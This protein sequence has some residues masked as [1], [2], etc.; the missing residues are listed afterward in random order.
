L[1]ERNLLLRLLSALV[2]IPVVFTAVFWR[3][4]WP[5]ALLAIAIGAVGLAELGHLVLAVQPPRARVLLIVV[6]TAFSTA[7]YLWP[8]KA[9]LFVIAAIVL[10]GLD[11]LIAAQDMETA[12]RRLGMSAFGI[13]YVG[14]LMATLP[15]LRRDAGPWWVIT[16]FVVTFAND[17]GA[18]FAGRAL[19][20][21]KLA[22]RI[23]PGK[24]VE[25]AVGGLL[26]GIGMLLAMRAVF[27]PAMRVFDAVVIGAVAGVLGPIGDLIESMLKRA[28]GAKDSGRL[29]PGHGGVLDRIDSLLFVAA[30]V[31]VHTQLFR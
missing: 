28:A 25:G 16:V 19:G 17:T 8:Q 2:G 1:A 12:A 21:H 13:F 20:R 3:D 6:G 26:S 9:F 27:F 31:F 4:P 11:T 5:F 23:S 18:Y 22:P 10:L 24:T 14:G 29:I 30:Y 7:V 15:L